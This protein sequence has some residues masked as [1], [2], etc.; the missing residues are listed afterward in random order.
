MIYVQ[1]LAPWVVLL[2]ADNTCSIAVVQAIPTT[3][4]KRSV[5]VVRT[6]DMVL[7][8]VFVKA[9]VPPPLGLVDAVTA[10]HHCRNDGKDY[11]NYHGNHARGDALLFDLP[12]LGIRHRS[13]AA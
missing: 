11:Q 1:V 8:N 4:S 13:T 3:L 6:G 7:E 12:R 5:V 2:V 10:K 9:L